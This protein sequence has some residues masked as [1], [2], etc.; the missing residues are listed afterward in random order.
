[1]NQ[2]DERVTARHVAAYLP[3]YVN[4]RLPDAQRALVEAHLRECLA[5]QRE[6]DEWRTLATAVRADIGA[7]PDIPFDRAWSDLRSRLAVT[8]PDAAPTSTGWDLSDES[9]DD[10]AFNGVSTS[11]SPVDAPYSLY[12]SNAQ[13]TRRHGLR[14][15]VVVAASVALIVSGFAALFYQVGG[16]RRPPGAATATPT[17]PALTWVD[18]ALP[19]VPA[20][21]APAHPSVAPNDGNVAYACAI[22]R[23]TPNTRP[24]VLRSGDRADMDTRNR[25]PL[26]P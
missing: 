1:M 11:T 6:C 19:V 10:E 26:Y 2:H 12:S 4:H 3:A 18:V 23:D 17:A 20:G 21:Y 15:A 22:A 16:A 9:D 13:Q 14:W 7:S 25:H 8:A 24:L 5:C